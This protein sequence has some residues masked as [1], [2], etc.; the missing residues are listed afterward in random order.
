MRNIKKFIAWSIIGIFGFIAS[1]SA[2]T[3]TTY[4]RNALPE[5]TDTYDLGSSTPA[6][7]WLNLF[8]RDLTVASTTTFSDLSASM[9]V[10]TNG[11]SALTS[12]S[13]PTAS[14]YLATSTSAT[15][16]F[17]GNLTVVGTLRAGTLI[18]TGVVGGDIDMGGFQIT[19]A[20]EITG[21]H[22]T[23]TST[24]ASIFPYASSTAFTTSNLFVTNSVGTSLIS[25]TDSTDDLGSATIHWANVYT[26]RLISSLSNLVIENDLSDGDISFK[27]NDGGVD[28]TVMTIDGA[29]RNVGIGAT[30]PAGKLHIAGAGQQNLYIEDTSTAAT[31]NV[32]VITFRS[33]NSLPENIDYASIGLRS[34]GITDGTEEGAVTFATYSAGVLSERM[35]IMGGNVGIG[36][37]APGN[38]ADGSTAMT[39][40]ILDVTNSAG[41]GRLLARGSSGGR[42]DLIDSGGA[43][44]DKHLALTVDGGIGW[45]KSINDVGNANV[46]D[47]I[48][49]M[50]LGTGNVGIGD[51]TPSY[52]LDINKSVTDQ[53]AL[54]IGE[55]VILTSALSSA[56]N[57]NTIEG[58]RID[59]R[60][61]QGGFNY[62]NVTG[63]IAVRGLA[64]VTGSSGIVTGA[65]GI[66]GDARNTGAGTLSN[67]Y[68]LYAAGNSNSGG[69]TLTNSYGVYIDSQ[70]GGS[71]NWQLYS[72]GT[73][74]S[75][76]AGN[77]GIGTTSPWGKLS[78]T[79]TGSGPSFVVEDDTSPDSTP[80][81]ID[82]SGLVG[83]GSTP[84]A[85]YELWVQASSG[86]GDLAV[87]SSDSNSWSFSTLNTSGNFSFYD[88]SG[89]PVIFEDD[90]PD[91]S[92]YLNSSGFIG[93]GTSTPVNEIEAYSAS[94]T[95]TISAT[96]K[97]C[98]EVEDTV[99]PGN[100]GR[101]YFASGV[102][103]QEAGRC[104]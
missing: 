87:V 74:N 36:T 38:E 96:K 54:E 83:I 92:L 37:V 90:A 19:D 99:V 86:N 76:F 22:F 95:T 88:G 82:E 89:F 49:V 77:V 72:A 64:R 62:T 1:A 85:G 73:A 32:G 18:V 47:N 66:Y 81:I 67:A 68:A 65:V 61:N 4:L 52:P 20:G 13:T 78:V 31:T 58:L 7:R 79:N 43:S 42:L 3:N 103:V 28:T 80:F 15:S 41:I 33:P 104:K 53:A 60:V 34:T 24:T 9:L 50:D 100:F 17:A 98:I 45:F 55:Q 26:D 29:T 59:T 69:G 30:T 25:D 51:S 16:N 11:S 75:Y 14:H 97:G 70:A 93:M 35:R 10:G 84:V 94:A 57:A 101:M 40:T 56:N 39:G 6:A 46:V 23:A 48:L 63:N 12:T 8:V 102:W 5:T 21:T 44:N 71:N 91:N 27:V 2:A